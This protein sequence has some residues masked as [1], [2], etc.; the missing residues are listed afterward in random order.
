MA[1]MVFWS[2]IVLCVSLLVFYGL[3]LHQTPTVDFPIDS[4]CL[5]LS[6]ESLQDPLLLYTHALSILPSSSTITVSKELTWTSSL[7]EQYHLPTTPDVGG[8]V[9]AY[10]V[11]S[12]DCISLLPSDATHAADGAQAQTEIMQ[13]FP[14]HSR[15]FAMIKPDAVA[16]GYTG[17]IQQRIAEAGFAIIAQKTVR[18][19]NAKE[20]YAEHGEQEFF[21]ELVEFMESSEVVMMVLQR[22]NAVFAWRQLIGPTDPKRA[23]E[24]RGT[25]RGA[26]GE[27]VTRN[28]V[29]GSDSVNSAQREITL[30]FPQLKSNQ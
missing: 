6:L 21:K 18:L 5:Y 2:T 28:A 11:Q 4:E 20:F 9:Y 27:S 19:Q 14:E 30:M 25:L 1:V 13:L 17:A 7:Q 3:H 16:A 15:T 24:R 10:I 8:Q 26:F 23:Q 29:H 12:S 22:A